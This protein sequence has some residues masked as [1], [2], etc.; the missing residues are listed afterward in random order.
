MSSNQPEL[1]DKAHLK[2]GSPECSGVVGPKVIVAD[3]AHLVMHCAFYALQ[4]EPIM[5][6]ACYRNKKYTKNVFKLEHLFP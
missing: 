4:W 1:V 2:R 5:T 3:K 6:C